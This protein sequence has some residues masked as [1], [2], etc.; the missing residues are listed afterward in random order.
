MPF[1]NPSLIYC[2]PIQT[3]FVDK[4]TG[5][6]LSAGVVTFYE[7]ENRT[8]LKAIYQQSNTPPYTY[9][10]LNNPLTLT[11]VG[12][13]ADNSGNDINV[14][15][16]PFVGTPSDIIQGAEELY[17]IT[18]YSKD[19]VLQET[20]SAF[21]PDV[22]AAFSSSVFVD[23]NN[24]LTNPQFVEVLFSTPTTFTVSGVNVS[25]AIAPG[26][27][28]LTQGS[29]TFTVSQISIPLATN[30]NA[31]NPPYALQITSS[32]ITG[33]SLY[34]RLYASPLILAS[35]FA[36]GYAQ[37]SSVGGSQ[38]V[39][40]TYSPSSGTP[41]TLLSATNTNSDGSF[42]TLTGSA[43]IA[44]TNTA[45]APSG[46]VDFIIT[47]QPGVSFD[48]TSAQLVGV[49]SASATVEYL[50]QS[51]SEQISNLYWYD[52]PQL[53]VMQNPSYL[54]GWDFPCNP[55]QFGSTIAAQA[56]G[57]NT[58]YYAWD[59][60]IIYQ[61]ATSA[62]QVSRGANKAMALTMNA[63][64]QI[65]VIQYLQGSVVNELLNSPLCVNVSAF[66]SVAVNAVV[67]LWYTTGN[68][69]D[70]TATN[71]FS[72]I[73]TIDSAGVPAT[74]HNNGG[75]WTQVPRNNL[76]NAGITI[77][78]SSTTNFNDYPLSGWDMKGIAGTGTAVTFAIVIG[79]AS[80]PNT[81]VITLN[82]VS[83]NAGYIPTRPAVKSISQ[84]LQ[85]CQHYYEKSYDTTVAPGS[86]MFAGALNIPQQVSPSGGTY[87][88]YATPFSIQYNIIKRTA[89]TPVLY[90]PAGTSAKVLATA[91]N[92]DS[93][94]VTATE[95]DASIWGVT[96]YG[97]KGA[98]YIG[99][100]VAA[101]ANAPTNTNAGLIGSIQFQFVADSR[102]GV[103]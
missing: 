49:A 75:T 69:P 21:P 67:S 43:A 24:Q 66:A 6:P 101:L 58:S 92:S 42:T 88:T 97:L 4:D 38:L 17:Y 47:L 31:T 20:R 60:T 59:Q 32:S 71:Y 30:T 35:G 25:T 8:T 3:Y 28:V 65:A 19:G 26:W 53:A 91:G 83:L 82:S 14:F 13:F 45:Q 54:I 48:V 98:N 96:A 18:V 89:P 29:G 2:V 77:G 76:G 15:L 10:Q 55:A 78:T 93:I 37:V 56:L 36:A 23:T 44:A 63:T 51:T 27:F 33:I 100:N 80:V 87:G 52:K 99:N 34:Q 11:S 41:V 1:P 64:T 5:A 81:T 70:I 72:L 12:T 16:Y 95:V 94:T 46:Y 50:Q 79:T 85:D 40:L 86:N 68:A 57:A 7:D 39:S 61:L 84:T 102:L 62:V 90:S 74:F 22:Q 9:T 103:I 73:A